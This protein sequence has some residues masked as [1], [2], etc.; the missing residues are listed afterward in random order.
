M[1]L[2][3]P[4]PGPAFCLLL[5]FTKKGSF[6]PKF[7]FLRSF[8]DLYSL[9]FDLES[10]HLKQWEFFLKFFEYYHS[11]YA[12]CHSGKGILFMCVLLP[13]ATAPLNS[14]PMGLRSWLTNYIH[15]NAC[16]HVNEYQKYCQHVICTFEG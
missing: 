3:D 11:F 13:N 2:L 14:N 6:S 9:L 8:S 12:D 16:I 15:L 1:G 4:G 10:S 5:F 7:W